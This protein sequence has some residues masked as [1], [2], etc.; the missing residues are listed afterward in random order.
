LGVQESR[1]EYSIFVYVES[2]PS[3]VSKMTS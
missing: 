2:L 3:F 1:V